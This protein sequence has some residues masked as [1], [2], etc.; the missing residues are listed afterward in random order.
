MKVESFIVLMHIVIAYWWVCLVYSRHQA[1]RLEA[2]RQAKYAVWDA[3]YRKSLKEG[4]E[5]YHAVADAVRAVNAR[6]DVLQL[7][8]TT[9][10]QAIKDG[11]RRYRAGT[12]ASAAAREAAHRA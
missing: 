10:Q 5:E 4:N 7:W 3:V 11:V 6:A 2:L 1:A 12:M 9:Y 8:K